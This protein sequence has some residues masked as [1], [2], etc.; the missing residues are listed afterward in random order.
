M[1][2][3]LIAIEP[4]TQTPSIITKTAK[5]AA[6]DLVKMSN[7]AKD[8]PEKILFGKMNM[9]LNKS[10]TVKTANSIEIKRIVI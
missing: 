1:E 2:I 6:I 7:I 5:S 9:L 3:I 10:M 4:K 8:F